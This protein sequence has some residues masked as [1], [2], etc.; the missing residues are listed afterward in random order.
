MAARDRK[1]KTLSLE[2]RVKVIRKLDEGLT[3]RDVAKL[4]DCGK[5]QISS[6]RVS[7]DLIMKEW[8]GGARHDLKYLKRRKT[9]YEDINQDVYDWFLRNRAKHMPISGPM[10]Q[11]NI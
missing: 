4:F 11:V 7:R 5:T 2:Q 8:E 10:I 3:V 9:T 1:R 6:I